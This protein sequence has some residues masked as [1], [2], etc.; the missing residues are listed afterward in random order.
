MESP[1]Y[2]GTYFSL[3][4][5]KWRFIDFP[6]FPLSPS[7]PHRFLVCNGPSITVG[8]CLSFWC[9]LVCGP[10]TAQDVCGVVVEV[11]WSRAGERAGCKIGSCDNARML[12]VSDDP[13]PGLNAVVWRKTAFHLPRVTFINLYS[14]D[15][16]T[17]R[18]WARWKMVRMVKSRWAHDS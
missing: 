8:M 3:M 17:L 13:V 7:F 10:N 18:E 4:P 2:N 1:C 11:D 12:V 5:F 14:M 15:S 6:P 9:N 16:L